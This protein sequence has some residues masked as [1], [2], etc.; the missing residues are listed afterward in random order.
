MNPYF[1]S[2]YKILNKSVLCVL[3]V[4]GFSLIFLAFKQEVAVAWGERSFAQ[5]ISS[6][7]KQNKLE[8]AM[9]ATDKYI[10]KYKKKNYCLGWGYNSK[11]VIFSKMYEYTNAIYAYQESIKY[12]D[13]EEKDNRRIMLGN[14]G[15]LQHLLGDYTEAISYYEKSIQVMDNYDARL[16]YNKMC[17]AWSAFYL[18]QGRDTTILKQVYEKTKPMLH[19]IEDLQNPNDKCTAYNMASKIAFQL[20]RFDEAIQLDKTLLNINKNELTIENAD[21]TKLDLAIDLLY[22]RKEVEANDVFR[23]VLWR[24]VGKDSLALWYWLKGDE[25]L[26]RRYLEEYFAEECSNDIAR[27]NL[28]GA[29]RRDEILPYDAW[30]DARK[31]KWFRVLVYP[32]TLDYSTEE[33]TEKPEQETREGIET[34]TNENQEKDGPTTV[35]ATNFSSVFHK[36]DCSKLNAS[37]GL[38]K[39]DTPQK[40]SEAGCLPC[41]YCKP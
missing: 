35:F 4:F 8:D 14:I 7:I 24:D 36:P 21:S 39:F 34:Y 37:E 5:R 38:I 13:V 11:G 9:E 18:S 28:R 17:V 1:C 29:I 2:P 6:L 22:L 3:L 23:K 25:M 20:G 27:E 33:Y 41:N 30:R 40:A 16:Y 10:H 32:K 12:L 31:K 15:R 19:E 26:A